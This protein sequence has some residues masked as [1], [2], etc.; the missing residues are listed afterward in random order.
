LDRKKDK[1]IKSVI[2]FILKNKITIIENK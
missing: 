2:I 1:I